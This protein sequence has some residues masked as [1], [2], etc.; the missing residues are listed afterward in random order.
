MRT[1]ERFGKH[2]CLHLQYSSNPKIFYLT[3]TWTIAQLDD[4]NNSYRKSSNKRPGHI[5]N[6]GEDGGR[7]I[8]ALHDHFSDTS[9]AHKHQHKLFIDIKR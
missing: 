3:A 9:S 6:S 8:V 4:P 1:R 5:S 2:L 7:Q